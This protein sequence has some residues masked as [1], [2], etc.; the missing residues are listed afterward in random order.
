LI[1]ERR[2]LKLRQA[3]MEVLTNLA[4]TD[5]LPWTVQMVLLTIIGTTGAQAG[6]IRLSGGEDYAFAAQ[7]NIVD[8]EKKLSLN[9]CFDRESSFYSTSDNGKTLPCMF[10]RELSYSGSFFCTDILRWYGEN[11]KSL[12]DNDAWCMKCK[13]L[14]YETAVMVPVKTAGE[15]MGFIHLYDARKDA[16]SADE[17]LFLETI[18]SPLGYALKHLQDKE[19]I[20]KSEE[21]FRFLAE[22]ARDIIFRHQLFPERKFSY[23]S[24]ASKYISG[25]SPEEYYA[26]PL[27]HKNLIHPDDYHKYENITSSSANF[28]EPIIMRWKCKDGKVIWVE[29]RCVPFY[30]KDRLVGIEGIARDI[31][32]RVQTEQKLKNSY[33]KLQ[34][35]STRILRVQEEERIRLARELHDEVGQA[36]TVLKIDL[37]LLNEEL[38]RHNFNCQEKLAESIGLVDLTLER[39]RKQAVSLRPPALDH[40]GLVAAVQNMTQG[41][42]RRTGIRIEVIAR[43]NKTRSSMEIETAL[44]RCIQESLTNV[45]RHAQASMVTIELV[46]FPEKVDARVEDNGI[47]FDEK[48]LNTSPEHIGLTGMQER[49]KLLNGSIEIDSEPGCGTRIMISIPLQ[50][51][52]G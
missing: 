2:L 44:F 26:D 12:S 49:V 29:L 14:G 24:P 18:S 20:R 6:A 10:G 3:E 50:D 4:E 48:A 27:F 28:N 1:R 47:G 19:L 34:A 15:I 43:E 7:E 9:C 36:L 8:F 46:H 23:V 21:Q 42:S 41:F 22:N 17:V 51:K 33:D 16:L 39:V 45:A 5:N 38:L 30:D 52:K 40:M 32:D 13:E 11:A 31:T 37:Q 25:Y 35:L